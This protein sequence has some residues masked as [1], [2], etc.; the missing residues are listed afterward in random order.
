MSKF[1][2]N[3]KMKQA[4]L[5]EVGSGDR[6]GVGTGYC[7]PQKPELKTWK[8]WAQPNILFHMGTKAPR[9]GIIKTASESSHR[10]ESSAKK[11]SQHWAHL[12]AF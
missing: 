3:R 11:T 10:H 5:V 1:E 7:G 12:N 2:R 6:E 9:G 4:A 8:L